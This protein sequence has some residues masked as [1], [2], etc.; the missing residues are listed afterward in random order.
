MPNLCAS[1]AF[2]QL[3]VISE[4]KIEISHIPLRGIGGPGTFNPAGCGVN[5]QATFEIILPAKS[6][7]DNARAFRLCA[8]QLGIAGTMRFTKRVPT[9]HKRHGL[10]IIHGH[11]RE[12]FADVIARGDG[13]RIAVWAFRVHVN[14]AHSHGRQRVFQLALATVPIVVEPALF[15]T[16]ID[17]LFWLPNVDATA[18]EAKGFEPH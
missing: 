17:I 18:P 16:P 15:A 1:R 11:A 9:G 6:L 8:Y 3:P 10:F 13:I 5:A 4:E 12:G 2:G 7:L 14:Q